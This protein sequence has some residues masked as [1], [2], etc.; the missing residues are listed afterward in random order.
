M[1]FLFERTGAEDKK[2]RIKEPGQS[3]HVW[4]LLRMRQSIS[5]SIKQRYALH[6]MK[7]ISLRNKCYKKTK[8]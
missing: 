5:K 1:K 3:S 2:T 7:S 8:T 4:N 6:Q